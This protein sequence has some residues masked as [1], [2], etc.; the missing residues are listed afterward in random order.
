MIIRQGVYTLYKGI[1]MN[2]TEYY[3]HGLDQD[4]ELNHRIL[5]YPSKYGLLDDFQYDKNSKRYKKDILIT[6]LSNTFLVITKA[7][8]KNDE[9]MVWVYNDE[10][11]KI[12]LFTRNF[13]LGEKHHFLKL[14]DKYIQ[15]VELVEVE[16]IWEERTLSDYNFPFPNEI[17]MIKEIKAV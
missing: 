9:F 5:S 13:N 4:I 8:Y 10:T 16:K 1:E 15:E 17:E 7:I 14:T 3:G 6:E 11:K 2:L 12:T